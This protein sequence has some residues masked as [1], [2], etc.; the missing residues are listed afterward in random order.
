MKII[1]KYI[2][3]QL[4]ITTFLALMLLLAL[5]TFLSLIDQLGDSGKGNYDT[6][7]VLKYVLLSVPRLIYEL[8]PIAAVIGGMTALGIFSY[9]NELVV[10]RTAGVSLPRLCYVMSKGA[11]VIIIFSMVIGELIAPLCEQSAQQMRSMALSEQIAMKTSN[12]FWSRDANSYINIRK[13]L[14]GE[15]LGDIYIYEFENKKLR[16]STYAESANFINGKWQLKNIEQTVISNNEIKKKYIELA[17]WDS[18][19]SPD[20]INMIT[21]EPE[22]LT[23][24]GLKNYIEYLKLNEQNSQRYAQAMWSKIFS[25]LTILVMVLLA[26]PLVK[27]NSRMTSVGQRVFAGCLIGIG[28]YFLSQ[29]SSK[30]GI[31]YSANPVLVALGPTMI[32]MAIILYMLKRARN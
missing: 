5:F 31:V 30:I 7:K 27:S 13:I 10:L 14:P 4:V 24:W 1:D 2:L 28:F 18:L 21:I 20:V 25:P 19:L 6:L 23:I 32:F 15:K 26:V 16:A 12:G 9:N 8:L 17:V 29:I 22:Y 11:L 3:S